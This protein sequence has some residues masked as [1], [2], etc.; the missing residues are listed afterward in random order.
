MGRKSIMSCRALPHLICSDGLCP[1]SGE[2]FAFAGCAQTSVL[3]GDLYTRGLCP[4]L[5]SGE[6]T[7]FA[8]FAQTSVLASALHIRGLCPTPVLSV[9]ELRSGVWSVHSRASPKPPF[10][11]FPNSY[12]QTHGVIPLVRTLAL[13]PFPT[14]VRFSGLR[15]TYCLF[16]NTYAQTHDVIPLVPTLALFPFSDFYSLY[17]LCPC[18]LAGHCSTHSAIWRGLVHSF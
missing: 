1:I 8:G 3:A 5:C 17:V 15:S 10:C 4:H 9:S 13:F 14:S 16:P 6:C 11:L 2:C 12:V 7:A 18:N